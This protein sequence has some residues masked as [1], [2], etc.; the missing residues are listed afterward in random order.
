MAIRL[1]ARRLS[2]AGVLL[3][4][5]LL[6]AATAT[7]TAATPAQASGM[8][9]AQCRAAGLAGIRAGT[10]DLYACWP[11]HGGWKVLPE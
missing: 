3:A 9:L 4:P 10:W 11:D 1:S 8:T 7:A 6:L 2:A 5:A